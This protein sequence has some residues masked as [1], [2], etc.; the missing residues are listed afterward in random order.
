MKIINIKND[1]ELS[2]IEDSS[3]SLLGGTTSWI[4]TNISSIALRHRIICSIN[5]IRR[6]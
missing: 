4:M 1:N 2:D 3:I 6:Q 5:S